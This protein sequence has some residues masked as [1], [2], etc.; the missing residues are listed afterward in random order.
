MKILYI[1]N[2][3][4]Q[5]A[6]TFY[7][8]ILPAKALRKRG[9]TVDFLPISSF[10]YDIVVLNRFYAKPFEE[11]ISKIKTLGAKIVY[12]TDDWVINIPPTNPLYYQAREEA[13]NYYFLIKSADV[14]TC[15]TPYLRDRI[16]KDTDKKILVVPNSLDLS[17]W[18]VR[19]GNNQKIKIGYTGSDS[20]WEELNFILDILI[21]LQRT[22]D[23]DVVLLG[24][25]ISQLNEAEVL[26]NCGY[27][28]KEIS[29]KLKLLKN[30]KVREW[31]SAD[32][33]PQVLTEENLDIGLVP[34]I[35]NEFNRCRSCLKFYEYAATNTLTIASDVIPYNTE[36]NCLVKNRFADWKKKL[37]E[38]IE[39]KK[40]REDLVREQ[41]KWVIENR[42][43]E[44]NA[45]LWEN[46]FK[47]AINAD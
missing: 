44:K 7:R 20:H 37:Q 34:L 13:K 12:E 29:R 38:L 17:Y 28:A 32:K 45:I 2:S 35:D 11:E 5:Q 23:F 18:R 33:Y 16:K 1:A 27:L 39:N 3:V 10:D 19:A 21:D 42:D 8:N 9:H 43:I 14:I 22:Y 4:V 36:V 30:L 26:P 6:S 46:A 24:L 47:E 41:R 25:G 15:T 31:T 40:L